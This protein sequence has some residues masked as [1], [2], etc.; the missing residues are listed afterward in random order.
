[1]CVFFCTSEDRWPQ[2]ERGG[3]VFRH[4]L[5]REVVPLHTGHGISVCEDIERLSSL[6]H[7]A[8]K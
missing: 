5:T 3:I 4:R 7:I 1:M 6:V 8:E 2:G